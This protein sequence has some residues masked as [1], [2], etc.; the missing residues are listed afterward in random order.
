MIKVTPADLERFIVHCR[1]K[2]PGFVVHDGKRDSYLMN[3]IDGIV[4]P[5]NPG[6][7]DD[8]ITTIAG[9]VFFPK[10]SMKRHPLHALEVMGHEFIHADDAKRLTFPLFA[11]L[12]MSFI[13]VF[14]VALITYGIIGSVFAFLPFGWAAVHALA[15]KASFKL[16][17]ITGFPLLAV[18]LVAAVWLSFID[19]GWG[20]MWILGSTVF[21][22]PLPAAGRMWAELRGYGASITFELEIFGR[23]SLEDKVWQFVGP[24]Y[25]WMWPFAGWV[26]RKLKSYETKALE[27]AVDDPA[28]LHV[29]GFIKDLKQRQGIDQ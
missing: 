16:R 15:V 25:Y 22:A 5:F 23:A 12:Y 7:L 19:D 21:L 6:F 8:F 29:L 3:L 26:A 20:A 10:G 13:S 2:V 17:R 4:W 27:E 28:L 14:L 11:G 18:S 1:K 9:A 24:S